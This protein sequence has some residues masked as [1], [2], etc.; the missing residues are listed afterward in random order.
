MFIPK[1]KMTVTIYN[2][3]TIKNESRIL[4]AGD[5]FPRKESR[6]KT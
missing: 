6:R 3:V 4:G 2:I 5:R 1:Q